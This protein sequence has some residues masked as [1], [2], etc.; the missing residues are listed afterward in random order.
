MSSDT[1]H[2]CDYDL[3][4]LP[5]AGQCPECG[6]TYDKAS[7]YRAVHANEPVLARHIG[8]ISLAVFTGII[9]ICGGM[10]SI[11]ADNTWGAIALTLI[12]AGVPGFGAFTYW[13][14]ARQEKRDAD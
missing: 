10:L 4:G 6:Q 14:S 7:L 9:L 12:I 1:C 3:M 5:S 13:W 11:K 2:H 8:W